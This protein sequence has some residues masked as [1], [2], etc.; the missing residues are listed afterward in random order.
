MTVNEL[1]ILLTTIPP[2]Y[3]SARVLCEGGCVGFDGQIE[4]G[5]DKNGKLRVIIE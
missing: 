1:R 2:E 4:M 5:K 3:D